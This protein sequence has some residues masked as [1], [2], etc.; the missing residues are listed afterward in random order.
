M[1]LAAFGR[2]LY[3]ALRASRPWPQVVLNGLVFGVSDTAH[4]FGLQNIDLEPHSPIALAVRGK[5]RASYISSVRS[6]CDFV[7][8]LTGLSHNVSEKHPILAK[9]KNKKIPFRSLY[10]RKN[11]KLR[12]SG[13]FWPT[14]YS[15]MY[16]V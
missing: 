7:E 9:K 13:L 16:Q 8:T 3:C 14:R 10:V 4:F 2:C 5:N 15:T 6:R 12:G 11:E 1:F